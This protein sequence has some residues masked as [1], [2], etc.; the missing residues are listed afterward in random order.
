VTGEDGDVELFHHLMA[1]ATAH[2]EDAATLASIH[3]AGA[4]PASL[5]ALVDQID[6]AMKL[7]L[8]A[9]TIVDPPAR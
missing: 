4:I 7:T 5:K 9:Q 1:Q 6:T 8:A 2:L 3:Q